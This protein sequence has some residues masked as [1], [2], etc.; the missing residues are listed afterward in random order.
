MKSKKWMIDST[1]EAIK[2]NTCKK[3]NGIVIKS[4]ITSLMVQNYGKRCECKK[5][6]LS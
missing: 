2:E 6:Y 4:Y 3:C 1:R 5:P